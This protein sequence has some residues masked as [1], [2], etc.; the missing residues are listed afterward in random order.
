MI[1]AKFTLA[2]P[3][4][5]VT[6]VTAIHAQT[7]GM[8]SSKTYEFSIERRCEEG[9]VSCDNVLLKK[10]NKKTG[11]RLKIIGATHHSK[12][13]DGF[14]PCRFVGYI[15]EK[16]GLRIFID[17]QNIVV[18]RNGAEILREPIK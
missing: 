1:K 13:A 10:L 3:L 18:T 6:S 9:R 12:C 7:K 16:D 4:L 17:Y 11:E 8:H 14:S 2:A 5:L 15:F